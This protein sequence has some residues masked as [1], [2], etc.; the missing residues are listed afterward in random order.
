M[1]KGFKK[2]YADLGKIHAQKIS[3]V[4]SFHLEL[5]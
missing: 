2:A 3:K 1:C 5:K 4:F